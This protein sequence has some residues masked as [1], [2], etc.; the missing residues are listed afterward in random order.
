VK[1]STVSHYSPL[2][3]VSTTEI[4][5]KNDG[6]LE[7]A[8]SSR[9]ATTATSSALVSDGSYGKGELKVINREEDKL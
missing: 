7:R 3:L 5:N 8:P 1:K 4:I 2:A 6:V 9:N